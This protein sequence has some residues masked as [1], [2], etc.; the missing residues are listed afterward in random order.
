LSQ[1][2]AV[3]VPAVVGDLA[4]FA[5]GIAPVRLRGYVPNDTVDVYDGR[6]GQWSHQ[7][8]PGIGLATT[9]VTVGHL[10]LLAGGGL[11]S[12][13]GGTAGSD[14]VHLFDA[15]TGRWSVAHLSQARNH[16]AGVALEGRWA[17]FAGGHTGLEYANVPDA[18]LSDVVDIYDAKTGK[19]STAKLGE[20]RDVRTAVSVGNTAIFA[21]SAAGNDNSVDY[22]TVAGSAEK[23]MNAGA[24]TAAG[25]WT[26]SGPRPEGRRA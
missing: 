6:T 8:V 21:W 19:W 23:P 20:A 10:A 14:V 26:S 15:D 24:W 9:E 25:R 13:L 22:F 16:M 5:G 7:T 18:A 12:G 17:I 3:I 1:A 4:V 2:R 11:G